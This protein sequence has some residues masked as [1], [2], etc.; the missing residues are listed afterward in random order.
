[1]QSYV[2]LLPAQSIKLL[3]EQVAEA[4]R[5]LREAETDLEGEVKQLAPVQSGDKQVGTEGL[6]R[7]FQRL[8]AARQVLTNLEQLL[9]TS[10]D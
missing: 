8:I 10:G 5:L 3:K 2:P 6:E 1:M 7:S 9:A 4:N